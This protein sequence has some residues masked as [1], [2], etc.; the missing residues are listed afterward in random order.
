MGSCVDP[1]QDTWSSC[2]DT[3]FDY[4]CVIDGITSTDGCMSCHLFATVIVVL[5][6]V[7]TIS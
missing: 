3:I 5:L 1:Y 2:D 7:V 6:S 4:Q